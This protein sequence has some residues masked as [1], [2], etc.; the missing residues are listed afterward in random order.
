MPL[1]ESVFFLN[2]Y[3]RDKRINICDSLLVYSIYL[4]INNE[5]N[6]SYFF[7]ELDNFNKKEN[8]VYLDY[9][10]LHKYLKYGKIIITIIKIIIFVFISCLFSYTCRR[11]N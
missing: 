7:P 8:A 3:L 9:N 11:N 2:K 5:K 10:I 6:K 4:H 1:Y